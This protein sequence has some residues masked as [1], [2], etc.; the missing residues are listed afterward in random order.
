MKPLNILFLS[1]GGLSN[2]EDNAVYPD[3]LRHFKNAGNKVYIVCPNEKRFKKETTFGIESG[4]HVLRVKTGN[5]TKANLIEKGFSTIR[6]G[7]QFGDAIRKYIPNICFDI[8]LYS[9]PPITTYRTIEKLKDRYGSFCYLMLKDIFP[10]NAVDMEMLTVKGFHWKTAVYAHFRR[11]EKKLYQLSDHIGCMSDGNIRYVIRHNPEIDSAKVGLCPNT[12]DLMTP[13]RNKEELRKAWQIPEDKIVILYGGN[14]GKPQNVD[15]IVESLKRLKQEKDLFFIMCGSGTDFHKIEEYEKSQGMNMKVFS[16]LEKER[17]AEILALSDIGL[18]FLDR[19]F[20]I[21]NIPSRMLDYMNY[22]LPVIALTDPNTDLQEII[23]N[24]D[25]GW[26][27]QS[28]DPRNLKFILDQ[29]REDSSV[30]RARAKKSRKYL[31]E[32][33]TTPVAYRSILEAYCD[34]LMKREGKRNV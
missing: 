4:I 31:E 26:W 20:T 14:F 6:I 28:D 5:I 15:Y 25:F 29:I 33:Y 34:W 27:A 12:I 7:K 13:S 17:Y 24:G 23:Q 19:R 32:N 2:L 3:L 22:S 11:I 8:I 18:I 1:I 30:I 16:F 10:Q 21:P 9:T